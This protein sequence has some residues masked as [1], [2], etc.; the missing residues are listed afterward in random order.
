MKNILVISIVLM[1]FTGGVFN[2]YANVLTPQMCEKES[3]VELNRQ[4]NP[5]NP[6]V[7]KQQK[8]FPGSEELVS[9]DKLSRGQMRELYSASSN[10]KSGWDWDPY[11]KFSCCQ[12]NKTDADKL[13]ECMTKARTKAFT[14]EAVAYILST[15]ERNWG[16]EDQTKPSDT[17]SAEA[18][19]AAPKAAAGATVASI[20]ATSSI[21]CKSLGIETVDY[22]ACKKFQVQL[23]LIETAQVVGYA[24][25]ELVYKDKAMDSQ[26]KYATDQNTA[27]AAL[28]ATGESLRQQQDMYD[29]RTAVDSTKLAYLYSIYEE[30]PVF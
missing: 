14:C 29:Q 17:A 20:A 16:N 23:N 27:T 18:A 4:A 24:T 26:S 25:Q 12:E 21:K 9:C 6:S 5:F 3:L 11:L 7:E 19:A 30:M 28:K 22:E 8:Y 10:R 1:S 13:Q 15:Y 2:L